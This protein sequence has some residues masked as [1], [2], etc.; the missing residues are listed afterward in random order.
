MR[1]G[2]NHFICMLS[3]ESLSVFMLVEKLI[4]LNYLKFPTRPSLL[5]ISFSFTRSTLP[6][7]S[8]NLPCSLEEQQSA[9]SCAFHVHRATAVRSMSCHSKSLRAGAYPVDLPGLGMLS[10]LRSLPSFLLRTD[11]LAEIFLSQK[12][13]DSISALP[14]QGHASY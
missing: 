1:A 13:D 2:N 8:V 14:L 9:M 6:V 4:E 12:H 5:F 7:S 3:S 11:W 10:L